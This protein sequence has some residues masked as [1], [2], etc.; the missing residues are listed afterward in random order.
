VTALLG[1]RVDGVFLCSQLPLDLGAREGDE[2]RHGG[3]GIDHTR[4]SRRV[5]VRSMLAPRVRAA[6]DRAAKQLDNR[7][8]RRLA[9]PG[10]GGIAFRDF[11]IACCGGTSTRKCR[12]ESGGQGGG[13]LHLSPLKYLCSRE[14]N[15]YE[16][17]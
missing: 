9:T 13:Q 10:G 3:Q 8:C 12:F 2:R 11:Q 1:W 6:T 5:S 14:H 16:A 15:C 7:S 4:L 17:R